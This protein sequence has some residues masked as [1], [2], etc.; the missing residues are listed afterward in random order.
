MIWL[1]P[2]EQM[3]ALYTQLRSLTEALPDDQIGLALRRLPTALVL[4]PQ[5]YHAAEFALL[6]PLVSRIRPEHCEAVTLGL[7]ES[8][9]G[10]DD[11]TLYKWVWRKAFQLLDGCDDTCLSNVVDELVHQQLVPLLSVQQWEDAKREILAFIE[12]N[13]LSD[14]ARTQLLDFVSTTVPED[15]LAYD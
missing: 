15:E 2:V 11:A 14:A 5:Q 6:E 3:P 4:L 7:L 10:L 8:T 1:L 13:P 12:R 9:V